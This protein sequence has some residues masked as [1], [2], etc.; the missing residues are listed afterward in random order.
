MPARTSAV[1]ISDGSRLIP[2]PSQ[3]SD[4]VMNRLEHVLTRC[5]IRLAVANHAWMVSNRG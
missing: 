5:G 2:M 1:M 4:L 3:A